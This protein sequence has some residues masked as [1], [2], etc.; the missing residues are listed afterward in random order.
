M[1][2][3]T[4]TPNPA[5]R[6]GPPWQI[7]LFA[8]VLFGLLA[9]GVSYYGIQ[10]PTALPSSPTKTEKTVDFVTR[11]ELPAIDIPIP[12]GPHSEEFRVACTVCHSPLLV[13]TQPLLTQ[14]QWTAVVHK[15]TAKYGAPLSAEEE[16]RIV[17]YAHTVHGK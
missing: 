10:E 7:G 1:V 6:S 2:T 13:F 9:A 8:F 15:M 14:K 3:E 12:S 17:K 4:P 11:I 5:S 16:A